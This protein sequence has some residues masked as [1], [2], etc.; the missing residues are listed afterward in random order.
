MSYIIPI[1][2][3]GGLICLGYAYLSKTP[4]SSGEQ[5][6]QPNIIPVYLPASD[7]EV[8]DTNQ[9]SL[10]NQNYTI[11]GQKSSFLSLYQQRENEILD[12]Y[13]IYND[14]LI[15]VVNHQEKLFNE[16]TATAIKNMKFRQD[17]LSANLSENP[18]YNGAFELKQIQYYKDGIAEFKANMDNEIKIARQSYEE[19]FMRSVNIINTK[20]GD[21]FKEIGLVPEEY[22]KYLSGY[23][24]YLKREVRAL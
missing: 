24:T 6:I 21:K 17:Q 19:G 13:K 18:N 4:V 14:Q 2:A 9:L 3:I 22:N 16:K 12:A 8:L 1:M 10:L 11:S 7:I 20:Y 23:E 15:T 5:G